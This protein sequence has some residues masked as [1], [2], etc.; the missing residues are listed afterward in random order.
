MRAEITSLLAGHEPLHAR[1]AVLEA[2]KKKGL[3]VG[4]MDKP[5]NLPICSKSG[6]VIETVMKLRWWV[7]CKAMAQEAIKVRILFLCAIRL[8]SSSKRQLTT[9]GELKTRPKSSEDEW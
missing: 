7:S 6:D 1:L 8:T 5:M 3:Q 9:P 2:L 4:A